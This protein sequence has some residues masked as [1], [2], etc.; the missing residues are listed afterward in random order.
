M[1]NTGGDTGVVGVVGVCGVDV[2][3]TGV[4]GVDSDGV[5]VAVV[6]VDVVSRRV[7]PRIED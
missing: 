2:I 5:A 3:D 7:K 4:V 1:L 6:L